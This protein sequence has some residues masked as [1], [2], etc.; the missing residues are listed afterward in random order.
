METN[1]NIMDFRERYSQ[2]VTGNPPCLFEDATMT[3]V[4]AGTLEVISGKLILDDPM[5]GL[6]AE[7]A[8]QASFTRAVKAGKYPVHVS[9]IYSEQT[10]TEIAYAWVRF[11]N[12][13]VHSWEMALLPGDEAELSQLK[14]G[15]FLG[16]ITE[17]GLLILADQKVLLQVN[18]MEETFMEMLET[19]F[20][21]GEDQFAE[22]NGME[23][24]NCFC[25]VS[26][27]G[28][29]EYPTFWGL[30]AKQKPVVLLLDFMLEAI[31]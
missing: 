22:F 15:E 9:S 16:T 24:G 13:P 14:E 17:S 2:I 26:S 6:D 11:S 23:N 10:G 19:R 29:G 4:V 21:S 30:D 3:E 25:F 27:N 31:G 18:E 20:E 12:E 8:E 7:E 5:L 28:E 1:D